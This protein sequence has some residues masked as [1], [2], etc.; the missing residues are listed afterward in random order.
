MPC[1]ACTTRGAAA[2]LAADVLQH[3]GNEGFLLLLRRARCRESII[4]K[5]MHDTQ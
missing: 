2:V 4:E 1:Q 5:L 3:G